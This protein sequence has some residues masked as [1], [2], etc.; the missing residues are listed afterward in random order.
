MKGEKE[1]L[2]RDSGDFSHVRTGDRVSVFMG[3]GWVKG[4]VTERGRGRYMNVKLDGQRRSVAV[5]DGR[6]IKRC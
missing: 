5:W 6:N 4:Y 3:A 1:R 2:M